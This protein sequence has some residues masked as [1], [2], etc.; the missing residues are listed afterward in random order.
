MRMS[1]QFYTILTDFGK[2]EV[3]RSV[4]SGQKVEFTKIKLGDGGGG[5]NEPKESDTQLV[6]EVYEGNIT[7]VLIDDVNPNWIRLTVVIP[8]QEGGFMIREVGV[9]DNNNRMLAVGKY[10]ETYKPIIE[11]GSSKELT[12]NMV[13]EVSNADAIEMQIDPTIVIATKQDVADSADDIRQE[14]DQHIMADMPHVIVSKVDNKKYSYGYQ[15]SEEGKPQL[16]YKE[17]I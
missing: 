8:G 5:Y 10:P 7:S 6:R 15:I 1:E 9:F 12:I 17:V 2:S 4:Q 11:N 14:I 16:I 3:I 13:I